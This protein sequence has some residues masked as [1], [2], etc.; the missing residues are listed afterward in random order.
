MKNPQKCIFKTK[1]SQN[2]PGTVDTQKEQRNAMKNAFHFMFIFS[3]IFFYFIWGV[4]FVFYVNNQKRKYARLNNI[5]TSIAFR[6]RRPQFQIR[7]SISIFQK[8]NKKFKSFFAFMW[9]L[10]HYGNAMDPQNN[11]RN[12]WKTRMVNKTT[13]YAIFCLFFYFSGI[14]KEMETI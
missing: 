4:F 14:F 10:S 11:K 12:K 2:D 8:K 9:Q 6:I 3:S 13:K 1:C 5:Q 7:N